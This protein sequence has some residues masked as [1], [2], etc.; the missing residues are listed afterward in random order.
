[1]PSSGTSGSIGRYAARSATRRV[2]AHVLVAVGDHRAAAVPAAVADDVHLGGEERVGG[3]HDGADVEVVLPVLDGHVEVVPAGVEV[4]D[5]RLER[6]V[7][8]AVDHVAP[9]ALGEQLRVVL[10]ALGPAAPP[11]GRHRPRAGRAASGRTAPRSSSIGEYSFSGLIPTGLRTGQVPFGWP[12]LAA[13]P[14]LDALLG[15]DWMDPTGCSTSSA[16]TCSGSA[17]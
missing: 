9:V 17:C 11:M 8:V 14:D 10:L 2:V 7:A 15:M 4:G 6:P 1:M 5:D 13:I 3:A 16:P 12:L